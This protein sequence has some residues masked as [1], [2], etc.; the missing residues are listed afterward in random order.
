M[1][2]IE[3]L[4]ISKNAPLYEALRLLSKTSK[5]ILLVVEDNTNKLLGTVTDGDIRDVLVKTKDFNLF[6]KDFMNNT[7]K[8]ITKKELRNKKMIIDKMLNFGIKQLPVIDENNNVVDLIRIEDLLQIRDKL[9][10]VV[11]MA[12]GE[13]KRLRPFTNDIPKPMLK[14]H[15]KPL[16][17][18]IIENFILYGFRKFYFILNYKADIIKDYFQ[19]G[20]QFGVSIDYIDE[21]K[22]LGTAGGLS[23]L[24]DKITTDF[25]L[26]NSDI[27]TRLNF[28]TFLDY[29]LKNN[30]DL[31]ICAKETILQQKYGVLEINENKLKALIEKPVYK[32]FINAGI[33]ALNPNLLSLIKKNTKLNIP[34]LI[35][36]LIKMN[37][38]IITY[39][40]NDYWL[41]IGH[42]DD[43]EKAKNEWK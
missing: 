42:L 43:Y 1:K 40:L 23:L 3:D 25:I 10:P 22:K 14:I 5:Q 29:H 37:K 31:T 17:E 35:N 8:T 39:Y 7:P 26:M 41:D 27:L 18:I 9:N 32:N 30:A 12:G 36:D 16:L 15:N 34:N 38:K 19:D 20:T 4:F 13:G 2:N 11:I 28:E 6:V 33:Y 24:K 21:P